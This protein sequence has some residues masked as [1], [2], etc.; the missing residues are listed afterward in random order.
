MS[1][2]DR[3]LTTEQLSAMLD[4]RLSPEELEE[5]YQAHL[6]TCEL[7]QQ[8]LAELRQ[9][10]Q[11]LRELPQPPLPRSFTLP[12][13]SALQPAAGDVA[14]REDE[15][16]RSKPVTAHPLPLPIGARRV[17]A[18]RTGQ[19]QLTLIPRRQPVRAA[20]RMISGLVAVIGICF[21][22][23]GLFSALSTA[24]STGGTASSS[25]SVQRQSTNSAQ[26]SSADPANPQTSL[27]PGAEQTSGQTPAVQ[28]ANKPAPTVGTT[29]G[30]LSTFLFTDI[31]TTPGKFGLGILLSI[32][33]VMGF[34]LF[35]KRHRPQTALHDDE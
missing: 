9:T 10:V 5:G 28:P 21:V 2:L 31:N 17:G 23:T 7:C 27:T 33:G 24:T 34:S 11:M 14:T 6:Q 15:G 4:Q 18:R 12:V 30:T 3:H 35:K 26:P 19:A 20:L 13:I 25:T 29:T 8:E 32:L 16:E 22:L 1:L